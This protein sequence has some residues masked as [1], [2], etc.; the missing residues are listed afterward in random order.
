MA[1]S[2][3]IP[4]ASSHEAPVKEFKV[5]DSPPLL[6]KFADKFIVE[7]R[8]GDYSSYRGNGFRVLLN[9][10][11]LYSTL[12]YSAEA[13]FLSGK[14]PAKF[15]AAERNL[16]PDKSSRRGAKNSCPEKWASRRWTD[17]AFV[18]LLRMRMRKRSAA[19]FTVLLTTMESTDLRREHAHRD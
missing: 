1:E 16:T 13:T 18:S 5:A 4:F 8:S 7:G 14:F 9:L 19:N 2:T 10:H 15:W 12:R 17:G 6:S 3:F 11:S